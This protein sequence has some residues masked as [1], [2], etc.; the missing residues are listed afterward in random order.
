MQEYCIEYFK[1]T[2]IQNIWFIRK[3]EQNK[4]FLT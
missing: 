4:T 1:E 3:E 2:Y